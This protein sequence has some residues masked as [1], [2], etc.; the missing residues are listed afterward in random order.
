MDHREATRLI[1]AAAD[2]LLDGAQQQAL[3]R[4]LE[5]CQSCRAY[6]SRL[7]SLEMR[8]QHDLQARYPRQ[9]ASKKDQARILDAIEAGSRRDSM[10]KN[11]FRGFTWVA[12]SAALVLVLVWSI[13]TLPEV[14]TGAP[15]KTTP[16][17]QNTPAPANPEGP[18]PDQE[19]PTMLPE[20]SP[21]PQIETS[22]EFPKAQ[23][24]MQAT[25]PDEPNQVTVYTQG[26]PAPADLDAIHQ[27][28]A[29]FGLQ[30]SIYQRPSESSD[31]PV[32][33]AT[34]GFQTLTFAYG[35]S[36][37]FDYTQDYSSILAN[38]QNAPDFAQASQAAE[39]FLKEHGLLDLPY[40]IQIIPGEPGGV[41]FVRL[42]DERPVVFGIGHNP[43]LVDLDVIVGPNG[44]I[45]Q[46]SYAA[47]RYKPAGEF[48][49]LS[50]AEAWQSFL[51]GQARTR[52]RYSVNPENPAGSGLIAWLRPYPEGQRVDLYTYPSLLQPADAGG[53]PL[54]YVGNWPVKGEK[55]ALFA[56]QLSPYDFLHTW[57]T[58]QADEAGRRSFYL[59]GWEVS[60]LE[61][62]YLDGAIERQ[63]E[64]A[65]LVS[66]QGRFLLPEP[67]DGLENGTQANV[68][69][70]RQDG[71]VLDWSLIQAGQPADSGY[72]MMDA[73]GGGGGGGG[74][75][76]IGG[77][78]FR[79]V[80]LIPQ[81]A[82]ATSTP[83]ALLGPYRAGD[84]VEALS[85]KL[86]VLVSQLAD[87]SQQTELHI[88]IKPEEKD[89]TYWGARL[90]GP[91]TGGMQNLY[92]LPVTVWGK[93]TGFDEEGLPIIE[94][95]RFEET[96]PG[97]R[98]QAWL[99]TWQA[100][101]LEGAQVLLFTPQDGTS[102]VLERSIDYGPESAIGRPGERVIIE[103]L[104]IPGKSFG[105]Y[106]V[107]DELGGSMG[108]DLKDLS[109][110]VITSNQPRTMEP[111]PGRSGEDLFQGKAT[112]EQVELIYAAASLQNCGDL[113]MTDPQGAPWLYVQ[114][115]WR[116]TGHLEDGRLFEIQIQA[117]T[118]EYLR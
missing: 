114:P 66:D 78:I 71:D 94:V 85:G 70:V 109:G 21:A 69:G 38:N 93:V 118:E 98:V 49:I 32:Y 23:F 36:E 111:P 83:L 58:F 52:F 57:G 25:L 117:L 106:P 67:P 26:L 72:G 2:G 65:W 13:R 7:A 81:T 112:V 24:I 74:G 19:Q 22:A 41:R 53:A 17:L 45:S 79:A 88:W 50:A 11:V 10:F 97:L 84:R 20:A 86:D 12:L 91:Q 51:S 5:T 44:D 90:E 113:E 99:G 4:H 100:V 42:L 33:V 39:T 101:K 46:L 104:A 95:E 102:Y 87:G 60:P 6:A 43:S 96:Y 15:E 18:R 80:T 82:G 9:T 64:A 54:T 61:D 40:N 14:P 76:S 73:C 28:A 56:S 116:F 48:P 115:V 63:G 92:T 55:A 103:G 62:L 108:G 47:R 3:D 37:I 107:I 29:F 75:E 30:G 27:M 59:Q 105:G 35:S 1:E 8:L 68:R 16:T 34:D 77:G 110:Y 31:H 89:G